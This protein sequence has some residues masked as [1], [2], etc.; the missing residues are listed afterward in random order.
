MEAR[1]EPADDDHGDKMAD[2]EAA[3]REARLGARQ[4]EAAFERRD[5]AHPVHPHR[6]GDE[7][8]DRQQRRVYANRHVAARAVCPIIRRG[9]FRRKSHRKFDRRL[10]VTRHHVISS[11]LRP[12][13]VVFRH[14]HY[15]QKKTVMSSRTF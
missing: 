14:V 5:D 12:A 11:R 3:D 8:E 7:D 15:S 4:P 1:A 6:V 9:R 10:F 13:P 2:L